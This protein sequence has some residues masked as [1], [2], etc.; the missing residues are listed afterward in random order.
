[1]IDKQQA[2]NQQLSDFLKEY[3]NRFTIINNSGMPGKLGY[4]TKLN[5][6]E[7]CSMNIY[8]TDQ[9]PLSAPLVYIVPRIEIGFYLDEMGRVRDSYLQYWNINSTLTNC[10]KSLLLRLESQPQLENKGFNKQSTFEYSQNQPQVQM[11]QG[12]NQSQSQ[13][14]GSWNNNNEQKVNINSQNLYN[15]NNIYSINNVNN[16]KKSNESQI[17]QNDLSNKSIEELIYIYMNQDEYVYEFMK[18]YKENLNTLKDEV[19]KLHGKYYTLLIIL[20]TNILIYYI[21]LYY[22]LIYYIPYLRPMSYQ[23]ENI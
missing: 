13:G 12:Q 18:Q 23:K 22:I 5:R 19:N 20:N 1:M 4:S 7:N 21:L 15:D 3:K 11:I 10:V 2:Y 8:L 9:F 14:Q 16:Q 6:I 17:L